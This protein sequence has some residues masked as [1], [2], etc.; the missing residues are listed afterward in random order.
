MDLFCGASVS[1]AVCPEMCGMTLDCGHTC[2]LPCHKKSSHGKIQCPQPCQ[3]TCPEQHPC[4]KKCFEDC[5]KCF[6]PMKKLL[7]C[8]H[9]VNNFIENIIR[10][11]NSSILCQLQGEVNCSQNLADVDC[12]LKVI[13]VLTNCE[14]SVEIECGKSTEGYKCKKPCEKLL[15]EEGHSCK[16]KCFEPCGL[17]SVRMKREFKCGHTTTMECF[18][19]PSN[20]KCRVPKECVLPLC[21][22]RATIP[23]GQDPTEGKCSLPCDVRLDCGHTCTLKCHV[24]KD[25]DHENY[26]CK[27]ECGRMKQ[28]CKKEHRCGKKC[29]E[30][31]VLCNEKWKRTLPCGHDIFIECHRNDD[32]IFCS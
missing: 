13:K 20:V 1:E 28:G 31:C 2:P 29:F 24:Q 14:H 18:V 11:L 9:E 32:D 30:E 3:R 12:T 26:Q 8:G 16:K 23:C 7:P 5:G 10:Q 21:G 6:T 27:K 17:C 4:E 25:P 22:H 19:D 15:C